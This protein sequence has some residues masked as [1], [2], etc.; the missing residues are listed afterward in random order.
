MATPAI[1]EIFGARVACFILGK[2]RDGKAT[3][4][5]ANGR[6]WYV[7]ADSKALTLLEQPN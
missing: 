1:F 3:V 6:I 5:F 7:P 4:R 2:P